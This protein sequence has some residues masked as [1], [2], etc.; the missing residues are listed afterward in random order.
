MRY[1]ALIYAGRAPMTTGDHAVSPETGRYRLWA[2]HS[3][4]RPRVSRSYIKVSG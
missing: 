4:S 3:P 2:L 1:E